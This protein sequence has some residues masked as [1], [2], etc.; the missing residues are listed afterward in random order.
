M[1]SHSPVRADFQGSD[2]REMLQFF[3]RQHWI[4]LLWPAARTLFWSALIIGAGA[5]AYGVGGAWHPILAAL[6][7]LFVFCHL[8]LLARVYRHFLTIIIV[9]D[10]K[11]HHVKRNLLS[12]NDHHTVDIAMLQDV[13][14]RQS[15]IVQSVM[16]YGTVILDVNGKP[17][18]I[19]FVPHLSDT[20][21]GI[22]KLRQQAG[23]TTPRPAATDQR[24]FGGMGG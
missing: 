6:A 16:G 12:L 14:R 24:A 20:H 4:R 18:R 15:G 5:V 11:F 10:R 3:F 13:V 21:E 23:G 8:Q 22:M 19:H 7:L 9:T 2:P 1:V 17:M